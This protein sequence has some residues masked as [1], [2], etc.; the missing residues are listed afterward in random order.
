[1]KRETYLRHA[2]YVLVLA[3]LVAFGAPAAV[4]FGG[5]QSPVPSPMVGAPL[6]QGNP[7]VGY[8]V[9]PLTQAPQS[10]GVAAEEGSTKPLPPG[11]IGGSGDFRGAAIVAKPLPA[12]PVVGVLDSTHEDDFYSWNLSAGQ[13][14]YVSLNGEAGTDFDI[15][16]FQSDG[17]LIGKSVKTTYPDGF[18]LTVNSG[19]GTF[20]IGVHRYSGDGEYEMIYGVD[21]D[22][23]RPGTRL[24]LP[25]APV[26]GMLDG[27]TDWWDYFNVYMFSGQTLSA[28]LSNPVGADFDLALVSGSGDVLAD[29]S[30]QAGTTKQLSY[31]AIASGTHYLVAVAGSGDSGSGW[32][33]LSYSRALK[34]GRFRPVLST[35]RSKLRVGRTVKYWGTVYPNCFARYRMVQ[36]Q[37]RKDGRWVHA[38]WVKLDGNGRFPAVRASYTRRTTQYIRLYMPAYVDKVRGIN[39]KHAYSA[40]RRVRWY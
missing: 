25:G 12:M 18:A 35:S 32:Y 36:V 6:P 30:S 40:A 5:D 16:L 14:A 34:T 23:H 1:M 28:T 38:R 26:Y 15:Y 24:L 17:S 31:K 9:T 27:Q 29:T 13:T 21:T 11:P 2:G 33:N 39:Y 22:S 7:D 8:Q 3:V 37:K 20:F 10:D 4:T 19:S